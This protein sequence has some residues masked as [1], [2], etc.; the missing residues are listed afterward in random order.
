V[1]DKDKHDQP[2]R[3]KKGN[4][5]WILEFS[6]SDQGPYENRKIWHYLVFLPAGASGHGMPLKCI[7]AFG[8]DPEGE[9]E[10]LPKHL[11]GVTVKALVGIQEGTD[12]YP[13]PKNQIV[14][15]FTPPGELQRIP[16]DD[17]GDN[18]GSG[19]TGDTQFDPSKLEAESQAAD[20][21]PKKAAASAEPKTAAPAAA[22]AKKPLWGA[23]K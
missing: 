21:Q 6:V 5:M 19:P 17:G 22:P 3:S 2:L 4:D 9:N 12:E 1:Q 11:K 10:I 7:K 16:M 23:R 20:T 18:G 15:F 8:W 13:D 14:K